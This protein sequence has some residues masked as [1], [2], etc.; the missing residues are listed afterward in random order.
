MTNETA[1]RIVTDLAA[2]RYEARIE[3]FAYVAKASAAEMR[4]DS[5]GAAIYD[6]ICSEFERRAEAF[7]AALDAA[8]KK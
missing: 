2:V 4:G 8:S 5:I 6:A 7:G 1:A 3:S